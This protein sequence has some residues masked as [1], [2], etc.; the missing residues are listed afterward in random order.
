MR[1]SCSRRRSFFPASAPGA[2][3]TEYR[4]G[5]SANVGG[6][7]PIWRGN[8]TLSWRKKQWGAGLGFYYTGRVTDVNATTTQAVWDSLGNPG[9]IQPIFNNGAYSY[10]YVIHDSKSYNVFVSYR[11]SAR[12]R[13]L[14]QTSFRLG[15]NNVFDAQPPLSADSRGY[16][17]SLYNV[18]ARGRTYSLQITKKL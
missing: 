9:Y 3:R 13:W 15:V 1:A 14:N 10:R 6:A 11:L 16:E 2:P 7:T 8:A 12:N 18:L 5:N 17:P 4:N